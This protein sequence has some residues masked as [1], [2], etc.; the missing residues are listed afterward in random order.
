MAFHVAA[1][2]AAPSKQA[3]ARAR[4][5]EQV[6]SP[7]ASAAGTNRLIIE[8]QSQAEDDE[9][10]RVIRNWFREERVRCPDI[11]HAEKSDPMVWTAD[12]TA[13][14]W[15]DLLLGREGRWFEHLAQRRRMAHASWLPGL[16]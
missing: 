15:S 7:I 1:A 4:L 13:G 9:D 6:L 12:A 5:L 3:A 11:R 14:L 16:D 8:Q 2:A 10:R